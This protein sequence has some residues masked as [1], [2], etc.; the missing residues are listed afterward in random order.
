MADNPIT[1][2]LPQ[3]LPQNWTYGQT[4]GPQGTDVGLTQQHGYNYLMQQVNAAQQ[5]AKEL[6]AA[7]PNLYGEGDIVPV[8][9]GGT[10]AG[11]VQNALNNLGAG[12]ELNELDNA[13]FVNPV[14]QFGTSGIISSAGYFIDRWK[15]VSGTVKITPSGLVLNGTIAQILPNPIGTVYS[16]TALTTTGIVSCTYD[17]SAAIFS[18]TGSGETFVAAKL[19]KGATQTLAYQKNGKTIKLPQ[20][21]EWYQNRLSKC[22]FYHV[23]LSEQYGFFGFGYIQTETVAY[24]LVPLPNRMRISVPTTTLN[25]EIYLWSQFGTGESA[26]KCSEIVGQPAIAKDYNLLLMQLSIEGG[27]P[28]TPVLAQLWNAGD[29][30]DIS[31]D[32]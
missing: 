22:M 25:G 29:Y 3:D 14:N 10:G 20:N 21:D 9:G 11:D 5:A 27:T 24:I 17:D 19:E 13:D 12:V 7:F 8:S 28:G 1:V 16:A 2:S 6:G 15:L 26:I 18:V 30:L 23:R 32:L 4:I 31:A